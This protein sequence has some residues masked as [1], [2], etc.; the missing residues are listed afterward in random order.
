MHL[1]RFKNLGGIES[2]LNTVIL[3]SGKLTFL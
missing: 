2:Q 1:G 3:E